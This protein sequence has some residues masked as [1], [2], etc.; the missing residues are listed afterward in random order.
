M[1][2]CCLCCLQT[3]SSPKNEFNSIPYASFDATGTVHVIPLCLHK[4]FKCIE[5]VISTWKM[6]LLWIIRTSDSRYTRMITSFWVTSWFIKRSTEPH[7]QAKA[8]RVIILSLSYP[9]WWGKH[10]DY[11]RWY[12]WYESATSIQSLFKMRTCFLKTL[13]E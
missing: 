4:S 3:L 8:D 1:K 13:L 7:P 9:L 5:G 6:A 10:R 2:E 12:W 11:C